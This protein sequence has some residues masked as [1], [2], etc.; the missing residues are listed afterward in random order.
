MS[1]ILPSLLAANPLQ[2]DKAIQSIIDL[3][4]KHVHIDMMDFHFTDNFGLTPA[5]C[6]HILKQYPDL[7]LDVHLMTQPTSMPLIHTLTNLGITNITIH[8]HTLPKE[9]LQRLL[10]DPQI[11]LRIAVLPS[12]ELTAHHLSYPNLLFLAVNPGFS[13]QKM[14]THVLHNMQKANE[15]GINTVLDGGVNIDNITEVMSYKPDAIVIGGGLFSATKQEQ[16]K[17]LKTIA[18]LQG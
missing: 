4:L 12:E 2:L 17:L 3:K 10:N 11:N 16:Q 6:K 18:D 7:T 8:P 5:M 9:Q 14:Q 13:H 15:A 1:T